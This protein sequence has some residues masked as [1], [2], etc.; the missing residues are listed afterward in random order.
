[1]TPSKRETVVFLGLDDRLLWQLTR[2]LAAWEGVIVYRCAATAP[3]VI[4]MCE[5]EPIGALVVNGPELAAEAV[6]FLRSAAPE[7]AMPSTWVVLADSIPPGGIL[8]PGLPPRT[9]FM[10]K[11]F[12]PKEFPSRLMEAIEGTP[13]AEPEA[14]GLP[15]PAPLETALEEPPSEEIRPP[16]VLPGERYLE[17]P[18]YSAPPEGK[19]P[20]AEE[21]GPSAMQGGE[22]GD[23]YEYLA[24]GFECMKNGDRPGALENWKAALVLRP[25]DRRLV[26]NVK[27]LEAQEKR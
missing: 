22:E 24:R 13:S 27:R 23:F 14:A 17:S 26:A 19:A 4:R 15:P 11:P 5:Q 6:R 7:R 9:L 3:E 16:V 18:A 10:E 20:P 12:N 25:D 21:P 8:V 2:A 1:M